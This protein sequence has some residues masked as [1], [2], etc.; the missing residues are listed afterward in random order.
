MRTKLAAVL[1]IL[2]AGA[3]CSQA[4]AQGG[5]LPTTVEAAYR[6]AL[7]LSP[8]KHDVESEHRYWLEDQTLPEETRPDDSRYLERLQRR[9]TYDRRARALRPRPEGIGGGCLEI[10]LNGC[11]ADSGGFIKVD[12]NR[13]LYWQTQTGFTD[14]DGSGGG[15]V[16]LERVGNAPTLTPLVWTSEGS[17]YDPPILVSQ[18]NGK[19]LLILQGVSRGTG[20]GD[21]LKM[22]L[23]RDGAWHEIDTDWQTRGRA[24]LN[25]MEVRHRPFW[26]FH[27]GMRALSPLWRAN[28]SGCCGE[29]GV[30]LLDVDI[31]DDRLTLT[32]V[33]VL[34]A[35]PERPAR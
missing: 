6:E 14:E 1:V 18:G 29:G 4:G 34:E 10:E 3:A 23:F 5:T 16:V 25:G 32:E 7:T 12:D 2:A 28:D 17:H 33:R 11:D 35:G 26:S 19:W 20:A 15:V 31:I 9:I 8:L 21:M 30:A 27:D 13:T 22:M 24:L